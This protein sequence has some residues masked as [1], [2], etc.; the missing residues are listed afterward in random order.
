MR[1]IVWYVISGALAA[2]SVAAYW[3]SPAEP[4]AARTRTAASTASEA[5]LPQAIG[6]DF[7]P[8][9]PTL[10]GSA[11]R[12]LVGDT[13]W[14]SELARS[15][16]PENWLEAHKAVH[17][18]VLNES[19]KRNNPTIAQNADMVMLSGRVV[20][21]ASLTAEQRRDYMS[22]L[23]RALASGVPGAVVQRWIA[24]PN[25]SP[26]DLEAR[27]DDPLVQA[28]MKET[29]TL[30]E[31]A[32]IKGDIEA[33]AGLSSIYD[34]GSIAPRDPARSAMLDMVSL[35]AKEAELGR[36]APAFRK[37]VEGHRRQFS[38]EEMRALEIQADAFYNIC[39]QK[40]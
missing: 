10:A 29:T 7:P 26:D 14:I 15:S 16:K 1:K 21:C 36:P 33:I 40:K 12:S 34:Y 3:Y 13:E 20:T 39:C 4:T 24:G 5:Q 38:P 6:T 17:R 35:K 8:T 22:W 30:L 37:L 31:T 2:A 25:G 18:C 32:A 23:D 11:S 28:W 19:L 27:R 9:T